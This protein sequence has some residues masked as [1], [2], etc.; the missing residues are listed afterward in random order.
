MQNLTMAVSKASWLLLPLAVLVKAAPQ[1]Q[2]QSSGGRDTVP[3]PYS[4]PRGAGIPFESFVSYSIEFSSF[5]DFAGNL[6][7]PNVFS[8]NLLNNIGAL[9]GS[10]PYIRVGGNTQ[11]YAVFNKSQDVAEIGIYNPAITEDY[12]TT[13]TIGPASKFQQ[14]SS[15]GKIASLNHYTDPLLDVSCC[16]KNGVGPC[17][18]FCQP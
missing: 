17:R 13:I 1:S 2:A 4:P 5:P 8:D 15:Q 3:L 11:D 7:N 6:S 10:K 14:M 16:N 9:S 18:R 12:P